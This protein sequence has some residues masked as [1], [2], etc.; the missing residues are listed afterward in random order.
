MSIPLTSKQCS[1]SLDAYHCFRL[2]NRVQINRKNFKFKKRER[3]FPKVPDVPV[4]S[5]KAVIKSEAVTSM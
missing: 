3:I 4:T 1:R 5:S 2:F